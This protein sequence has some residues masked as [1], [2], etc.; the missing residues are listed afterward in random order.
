MGHTRGVEPCLLFVFSPL[1]ART[2]T[3]YGYQTRYQSR[4]VECSCALRHNPRVWEVLWREV[5]GFSLCPL[6]ADR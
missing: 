4:T 2:V 5:A 1:A 3:I 6:I